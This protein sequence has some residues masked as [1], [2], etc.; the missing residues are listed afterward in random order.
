MSKTWKPS[1]YTDKCMELH[2]TNAI[3]HAHD[4]GC[5]CRDPLKHMLNLLLTNQ[6]DSTISEETKQKIR[7]LLSEEDTTGDGTGMELIPV[8][9]DH[10][11]EGFDIGDLEELFKE[12]GEEDNNG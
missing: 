6:I 11:F 4:L 2:I 1:P 5:G 9:A 12:D 3:F 10:G 8:H 7:C